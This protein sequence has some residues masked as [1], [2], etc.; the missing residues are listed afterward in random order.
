MGER[1][2]R[3]KTY[4]QTQFASWFIWWLFSLALTG[5]VWI[6]TQMT[7]YLALFLLLCII[8]M[9]VTMVLGI[10]R[11]AHE[12][13]GA[14]V[15]NHLQ[16]AEKLAKREERRTKAVRKLFRELAD[17]GKAGQQWDQQQIEQ[18]I[19]KIKLS[20]TP[21]IPPNDIS[22][23]V[24]ALQRE[25]SNQKREYSLAWLRSVSIKFWVH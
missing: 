11:L 6:F 12:F 14:D 17:E 21:L 15:L 1:W 16:Q 7:W 3:F 22:D 18:W 24:M 5:I 20:L 2:K 23:Y 9:V 4:V 13:H 10:R 19:G 8:V 25:P